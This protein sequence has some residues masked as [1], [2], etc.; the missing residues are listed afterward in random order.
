MVRATKEWRRWCGLRA[1]LIRATELAADVLR[2][3]TSVES[4]VSV[5]IEDQAGLAESGPGL[6]LITSRHPAELDHIASVSVTVK[7]DREQWWEKFRRGQAS[8]PQRPAPEFP[9]ASVDIRVSKYGTTLTVEGDDRT[10]VEG[11]TQRLTEALGRAA[12]NSPGFDRMAFVVPAGPFVGLGAAMG[13]VITR[14][15][16]LASRND[17]WDAAEIVS[18]VV[19]AALALALLGGLW[20]IF[21]PIEMFDEGGAG[22]ARRFRGWIFGV[23][24]TLAL[25][26]VGALLYDQLS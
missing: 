24:G 5:R 11:L 18:L 7:P 4:A 26:L 6:D 23:A 8:E 9:S 3:W 2:T 16:D 17:R 22:R 15:L 10:S 19:G 20:W 14:W 25:A 1:E 21:P 13:L 12:T